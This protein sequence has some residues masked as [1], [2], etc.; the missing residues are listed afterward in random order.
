MNLFKLTGD[1]DSMKLETEMK[2]VLQTTDN[3]FASQVEA[4]LRKKGIPFTV[5]GRSDAGV[6][7][8]QMIS[9]SVAE[10]DEKAALKIIDSLRSND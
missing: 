1:K 10:K 4:A 7:V 2:K 9:I 8:A 3:A 6:G 5:V